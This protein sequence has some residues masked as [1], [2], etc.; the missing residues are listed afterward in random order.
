MPSRSAST[1]RRGRRNKET[2]NQGRLRESTIK[3]SVMSSLKDPVAGG[4]RAKFGPEW[5]DSWYNLVIL[6]ERH[7]VEEACKE[8]VGEA[9]RISYQ[10]RAATHA[11]QE[12]PAGDRKTGVAAAR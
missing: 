3:S 7:A 2:K 1:S 11:L 6:R 9:G 12:P 8:Q 5:G 10:C 4:G